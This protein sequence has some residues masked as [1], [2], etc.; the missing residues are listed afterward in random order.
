MSCKKAKEM[1]FLSGRLPQRISKI[2]GFNII[3]PDVDMILRMVVFLRAS[4][5]LFMSKGYFSLNGY[6]RMLA[7]FWY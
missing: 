6:S 2:L 7:C 1:T 3:L 4:F 5:A